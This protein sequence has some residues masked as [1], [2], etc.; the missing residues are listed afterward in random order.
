MRKLPALVLFAL[1]VASFSV[2]TS[3]AASTNRI[4]GSLG[5]ASRAPRAISLDVAGPPLL[6]PGA[7]VARLCRYSGANARPALRLLRSR[8]IRD[9]ALLRRL[10]R[11]LNTLP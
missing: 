6:R 8:L 5:C 11:E 3:S 9:I 7:L 2:W 1:V 10:T 4:R